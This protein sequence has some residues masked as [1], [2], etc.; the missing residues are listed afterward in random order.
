MKEMQLTPII[1][2]L[3]VLLS[4]LYLTIKFA[5]IMKFQRNF[6]LRSQVFWSQWILVIAT[7]LFIAR[8][9]SIQHP[10][11]W[12]THSKEAC[13]DETP[14]E[15]Y[16]HNTRRESK[17]TVSDFWFFF[18]LRSQGQKNTYT[19]VQIISAINTL[20]LIISKRV[21]APRKGGINSVTD[22]QMLHCKSPC[23]TF[24]SSLSLVSR[25]L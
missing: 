15:Q 2:I 8:V 7:H 4:H 19:T 9:R 17:I 18:N 16:Q 23:M 22:S 20:L 11:A 10:G 6:S 14:R 25:T 5:R 1:N 3:A 21:P 13:Q 12:Q 24:L